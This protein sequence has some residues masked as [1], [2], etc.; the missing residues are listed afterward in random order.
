VARDLARE[1]SACPNQG[2]RIQRMRGRGTS[3]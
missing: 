1:E 3:I 2:T